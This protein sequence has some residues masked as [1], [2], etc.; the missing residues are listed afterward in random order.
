VRKLVLL[1]AV[2]AFSLGC[3]AQDKVEIFG[4]YSFLH[5]DSG[6]SGISGVNA[7][8]WETAVTGKVMRY[9]GITADVSGEYSDNVLGSGLSGASYNFLFGP[10]VMFSSG[11]IKPFAHALFGVSHLTGSSGLLSDNSFAQAYGG[12][13][14]VKAG[15]ML[16]IRVAQVDY[17]RTTFGSTAQNNFHY[18]GGVVLRF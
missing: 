2:L 7:N 8:G 16:A 13:I 10:T 12:G 15:R 5:T 17:V 6:V 18:S 11:R 14:D 4:G 9:L 1:L 3:M